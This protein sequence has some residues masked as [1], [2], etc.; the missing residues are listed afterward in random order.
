MGKSLI[1]EYIIQPGDIV[2]L[3]VY[4]RGG[5]TLIDILSQQNLA[6]TR[7][8]SYESLVD[9]DGYVEM[10]ILGSYYIEGFTE[11]ELEQKLENDFSRLFSDPF[12][13]LKVQ[14]RRVFVFKGSTAQVVSLNQ[15]PTNLFEVI[16]LAG[17]IA[18]ELKA[19]KIKI[20]RGDLKNPE[21]MIVDLS[22]IKGLRDADLIVQANDIIYIETRKRITP[23]LLAEITPVLALVSTIITSIVL[24]RSFGQ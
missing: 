4:S 20:I 13:I 24:F 2:S 19:Y 14:N 11:E 3:Q 8:G 1:E 22:T 7:A 12:V 16:A 15:A 21:I 23:R 6:N 10:P 18:S 17:G 9:K 5:F